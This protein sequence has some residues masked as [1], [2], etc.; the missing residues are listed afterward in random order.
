MW[1]GQITIE[2]LKYPC[3]FKLKAKLSP[4]V[5]EVRLGQQNNPKKFSEKSPGIKRNAICH[6][7]ARKSCKF[8]ATLPSYEERTPYAHLREIFMLQNFLVLQYSLFQVFLSAYF[9]FTYNKPINLR[10]RIIHAVK[11]S[12]DE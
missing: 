9:P 10:F 3:N 5:T 7:C 6:L 2:I 4:S 1:Y 11:W 8:C 12:K